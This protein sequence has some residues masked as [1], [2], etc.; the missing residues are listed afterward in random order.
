M[1]IVAVPNSGLY[2]TPR[3]A[4]PVVVM[5][6]AFAAPNGTDSNRLSTTSP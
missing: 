4:L 3:G 5:G 1:D 2:A 6:T